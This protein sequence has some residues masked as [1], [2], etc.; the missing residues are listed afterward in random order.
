MP[1]EDDIVERWKERVAACNGQMLSGDARKLLREALMSNALLEAVARAQMQVQAQVLDT[2]GRTDAAEVKAIVELQCRL[3]AINQTFGLL[4]DIAKE[5][6][7]D[8]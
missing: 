2:L 7:D 5:S 6:P 3:A 8:A 1:A 4:W